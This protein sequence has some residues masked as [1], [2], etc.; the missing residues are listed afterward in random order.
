MMN[1][2][3]RNAG[4]SKRRFFRV[5]P[6]SD[7]P[8]KVDIN[9]D[10]FIE[11]VKAVDISEGGIRITVPHRF[12]GCHVDQPVAFIISLPQPI[13]KHVS[14]EGRIKHVRNDSF[15]VSFTNMDERARRFIRLYIAAWLKRHSVW[16]YLRYTLGFLR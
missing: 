9:G 15:G 4:R 2:A 13:G 10:D 14:L 11:V 7:A 5:R 6:D 8:V 1:N 3:G 16:D 12:A